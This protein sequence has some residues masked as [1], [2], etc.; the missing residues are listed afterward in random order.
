MVGSRQGFLPLQTPSRLG[1][2]KPDASTDTKSMLPN[3]D[4]RYHSSDM[5]DYVR[6]LQSEHQCCVI[7]VKSVSKELLPDICMNLLGKGKQAEIDS[8]IPFRIVDVKARTY[9]L[10]EYHPSRHG[11]VTTPGKKLC[12]CLLDVDL[13]VLF[14]LN[15]ILLLADSFFE[16]TFLVIDDDDVDTASVEKN[17]FL[18]SCSLCFIPSHWFTIF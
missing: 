13:H 18:N 10:D 16:D 7:S 3:N 2:S 14:D 1:R 6:L 5:D 15:G 9:N 11:E 4:T 12:F 8:E 17:K